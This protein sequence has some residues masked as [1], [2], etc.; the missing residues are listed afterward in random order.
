MDIPHS[1]ADLSCTWLTLALRHGHTIGA[2]AVSGFECSRLGAGEGRYGQIV[3]VALWYDPPDTGA[4]RTVVAKFSA[5]NPRMRQ[6]PN[7]RVSYEREVR[8]YQDLAQESPI[9]VPSCY[10]ADVNTESGW[11]VLLLEDLAPAQSGSRT[12]GCSVGQARTAIHHIARFHA[13]WWEH[14]LLDELGWLGDARRA[15]GPEWAR[16]HEQWWPVFLRKVGRPLPEKVLAIGELL[17]KQRGRI[18]QRLGKSEPRTLRHGDY[19]LENMLF[20]AAGAKA[21]FVVDWGFVNRGRG[22]WD[23]AYFVSENMVTETRR[24]VEMELLQ[25]Y[26]RVLTDRGVQGY[27]LDDALYDYRLCLLHRFGSLISTIAAMPFTEEQIRMHADVLLPRN[28]AALLDHDCHSL[29]DTASGIMGPE[30]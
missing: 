16:L 23:V 5:S 8:F 10:Y 4:P 22:I 28:M 20:A 14:P 17:G 15:A 12:V 19:G 26:V 2:S 11:H 6:R 7:T 25:D 9:P 18:V 3:R 1:A 21:F 29:L 13:H 27:A 24:A 30:A